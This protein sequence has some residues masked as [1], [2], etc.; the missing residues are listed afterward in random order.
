[1]NSKMGARHY[2]LNNI[3]LPVFYLFILFF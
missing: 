2:N 1:M 3:L